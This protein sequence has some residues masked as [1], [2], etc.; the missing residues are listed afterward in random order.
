MLRVGLVE[1]SNHFRL[2]GDDLFWLS[3]Y[4]TN[5]RPQATRMASCDCGVDYKLA[6]GSNGKWTYTVLLPF[7]RVRRRSARRQLDHR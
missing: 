2:R 7:H 4:T 3:P 5:L 1:K 6:P